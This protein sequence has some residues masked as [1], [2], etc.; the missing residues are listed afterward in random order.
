MGDVRIDEDLLEDVSE[1]LDLREPNRKAVKTVLLRTSLHYDVDRNEDAFECIVDSATGVGKTYVL[2][3]LIEYLALADPPA[4]NFLILAPGR[5]IRD[6]TIRNF[7][8]GDRKALTTTMRSQPHLVTADNFNSPAT[9]SAMADPRRTKVYVF[10]VQ[11]LTSKTGEGRETHAFVEGLGTNFYDWLSQLDDLVIFADE[12]HCYRGPAFSRTIRELNPEVVVGLTAT[13]A[14]ADEDLVVYR[15]PL[16]AAIADKFVKTPVIVGRRDDRNDDETKLLDGVNLL[17]AKED[18]AHRYAD[19]NELPRVNPVMM[20][21]AGSIEKAEE[22]RD[23]LDSNGFDGGAWTGKT[24]L[25]HSQLTGDDKEKAL[26]DLEAV[27]EPDSAVRII[28]SVGMLKEGWDVKNVY[29]LASWRPS[30]S[31]VLTE[32]TLGRGL[33]LPFDSYTGIEFLDTLE[34]LAHERY[35]DLLRKRKALNEQ[36]ID[37]YTYAETR[38]RPDGSRTVETKHDEVSGEVLPEPDDQGSNAPTTPGTGEDGEA[39]TTGQDE[40]ARPDAIADLET[41]KREAEVEVGE[42]ALLITYWPLEG[43]P[44][45]RIPRVQSVAQKADVSL[46][47]IDL[48]DY[49]RFDRLGRALSTELSND[50]KRTKIVATRKGRSVEVGVAKAEDEIAAT[51]ALDIPLSASRQMLV[52]RVMNVPGVKPRATEH[53]AAERIVDRLISAMGDD[54]ATALSAFG[55]RCGQR[56]ADGVRDAVREASSSQVSY[57]DQV[58]MVSLDRE[59]SAAKRQHEGH[60]DTGFDRATAFDGWAKNL[61]SHAWFDS[62]PEYKA[63]AAVDAARSVEVWARLHRNDIPITWNAEGRRYNPDFVVIESVDGKRH[64]WLVETK[65]DRDMNAAEV[66]AKRRA[67]RRWV[68]VVNSSPAV[69]GVEWHY[70]LLGERDVDDAQGS[71]EYLREIGK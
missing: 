3:G 21:V 16:A 64:G 50:L 5:T 59:R 40:G 54:A 62:Q 55:E 31:D 37:Y 38:T 26:A 13:P 68:N 2:A 17:R 39:S 7:T 63:A 71:W 56:L 14:K 61:Y 47:D 45:V 1:R 52:E 25:V 49:D 36:F 15:Y 29:V 4:K 32:Q 67:A 42:K 51:I 9:R 27:D 58:D 20:I 33:R 18:L 69:E 10:T 6:K 8:P 35:E 60:P 66:V 43:R 46:N 30:V 19:E 41:R 57:E 11:A 22:L 53:G 65:A 44:D 23:I 34:V 70:L 12:H 48:D 28:F 24:L